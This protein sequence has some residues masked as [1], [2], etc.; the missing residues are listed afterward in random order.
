MEG[1]PASRRA[2]LTVA[3]AALLGV[4]LALAALLDLGPCA[5]DELTLEEFLSQ[6]DEICA[7]AHD[8]FLELQE[9]P[10]RTPGD[11][12]ELTGGLIEVAT[13]ER[14]AIA[15]LREPETVSDRVDRYLE[16]R[17][18]GIEVLRDGLAAAEDA[19][20]GQYEELQAELASTQLDPRY[21]IARELGFKTCSQP[22]VSRD[23]LERQAKRPA[24]A[25]PG[26]PPTVSNPPTGTP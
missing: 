13:E 22:L 8:E 17:D 4:L 2:G 24:P 5:D 23:E 6:G 21:Q 12:A 10:P 25:D 3:I 14:D 9:R 19:D 7:T 26:A 18:R 1:S 11:A 20:A 15:D 16:A